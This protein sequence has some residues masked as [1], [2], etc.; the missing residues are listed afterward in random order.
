MWK[1]TLGHGTRKM[2][3]VTKSPGPGFPGTW[4]T[5]NT[6]PRTVNIGCDLCDLIVNLTIF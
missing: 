2:I 5:R 3:A 6:E 4:G 1:L